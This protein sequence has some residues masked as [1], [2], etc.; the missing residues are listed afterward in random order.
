MRWL[1]GI[2]ATL[3]A[4]A[5]ATLLL[6]SVEGELS[7]TATGSLGGVPANLVPVFQGAASVYGLGARGPSI[8]AGIN[9]VESDFGQSNLSGVHSGANYAGAVGP[10]QFEPGTWARYQVHGPGGASPPDVY[11]EIDAVYAAA[12]YLRNSGAPADWPAAIFSYNHAG[13]YVRE[14]LADAQG[15]YA[16][17]LDERGIGATL[18]AADVLPTALAP[19]CRQETP[20]PPAVAGVKA[21]ILSDGDAEAP[22][23][24]P[25]AV[26]EMIAAG[27]RI[28][29]FAYSF[30][31]GHGDPAATMNQ[32]TPDPAAIPG[33]Q[34]NGAAGYDCSSATSYVLWGAGLG[35]TLLDGQVDDSAELERIGDPGPGRWVT[36]Y[37]NAEHAYI[38]VAGV[39]LDTAAGIR[40]PPNPPRTG[41]RW[42]PVG[43]GPGGFAARHPPGL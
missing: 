10:M 33:E 6:V 29:H 42:T 1:L 35:A 41:P 20:A 4:V 23:Q 5:M 19:G 36:I 11:D 18:L 22:A 8:L 24:A 31:G 21:E 13:W 3:V 30:G 26:K 37:A 34:E 27:N 7:C 28:N 25:Q 32:T 43:S 38:E 17:G 16:Q 12:N 2:C 40:R 14:I 39:Y 9:R 15:Y